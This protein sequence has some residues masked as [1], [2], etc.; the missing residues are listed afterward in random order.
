[1]GNIAKAKAANSKPIGG[2][3]IVWLNTDVSKERSD[4]FRELQAEEAKHDGRKALPKGAE[5][6]VTKLRQELHEIEE[7][8]REHAHV[9]Y[10]EKLPGND[11]ADL[12]DLYPPRAGNP[13]DLELGFNTRKTTL[14]AAKA[15][16][17]ELIEDS[18]GDFT[19][20]TQPDKVFRKVPLDEDDWSAILELGSG[21]DLNGLEGLIL[22]LNVYYASQMVARWKKG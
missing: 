18:E 8:E 13:T 20:P 22:N 17:H 6:K 10:F 7:R 15:T 16:G 14:A 4:K 1:M 12:S 5:T 3:L 21:Y 19:T 9:L 2:T 11:F